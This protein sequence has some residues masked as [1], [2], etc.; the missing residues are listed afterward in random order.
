MDA[1]G[2]SLPPLSPQSNMIN[3]NNMSPTSI[4]D[5]SSASFNVP[6]TPSGERDNKRFVVEM[7]RRRREILIETKMNFMSQNN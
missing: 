4:T 7:K 3:N 2:N 6:M 5:K 1:L